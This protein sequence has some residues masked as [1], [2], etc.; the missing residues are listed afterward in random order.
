[1]ADKEVKPEVVLSPEE[2]YFKSKKNPKGI[3]RERVELL[4]KGQMVSLNWPE[5]VGRYHILFERE[6]QPLEPIYYW[7]VNHLRYDLGFLDIV[8]VTD[9]F[10]AS[11]GS[12]FFGV[13][14]QKL[15]AQ[16]DKVA[17]FLRIIHDIFKGLVLLVRDMRIIDE[18]L[19]YFYDSQKSGP[20][21]DAAESTLKSQFVDM[22]EGG[23]KSPMSVL[24]LSSQAQFTILPD[25]FFNI[26]WKPGESEADFYKRVRNLSDSRQYS[27]TLVTVLER[28]LMSYYK[29]N[30][31]LFSEFES[32]RKFTLK[33]IHQQYKTILMYMNWVKPYLKNV[34]RLQGSSSRLDAPELIAGFDS[35]IIEIEII[36][37][38]KVAG[39]GDAF[40]CVMLTLE[41]RTKPSLSYQQE[42]YNRGPSHTGEVN[43]TFRSYGWSDDDIQ[44]YKS[45]RESESMELLYDSNFG[46]K[47]AMDSIG[48]ELDKY[49]KQAEDM[50]KKEKGSEDKKNDDSGRHVSKDERSGI[51]APVKSIVKEVKSFTSW[52][53]L[54]KVS[55]DTAT[56]PVDVEKV[57]KDKKKAGGVAHKMMWVLYKNFK[58]SHRMVTW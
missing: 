45:F 54:K 41:Y 37:K 57:K 10:S 31:Q 30:K 24:G 7:L 15:G 47:E 53:F 23:A 50:I 8:K 42:P 58:K 27:T 18:K 11:E 32:R 9:V 39:T 22:V 6:S 56:K 4:G 14:Q 52:I 38:T 28:K 34:Q 26:R 21:G 51:L 29:W 16:Q 2:K 17:S 55:D 25:L 5:S 20:V 13:V 48:V 33:Y 3:S 43:I 49:L 1:M 44:K 19:D 40:G 12:A 46:I 36:A 35:A